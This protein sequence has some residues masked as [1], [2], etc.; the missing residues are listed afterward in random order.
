[1]KP[2][3]LEK[4]LAGEPVITRDGYKVFNIKCRKTDNPNNA[5]SAQIRMGGE[6]E[7]PTTF[8]I[9]KDGKMFPWMEHGFD[10]FMAEETDVFCHEEFDDETIKWRKAKAGR[11]F[12]K[13][14]VVLY[15]GD[16]DARLVRCAIY[17]CI[18]IHVEDL[19]KLP[20]E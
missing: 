11:N 15:N 2:F 10:L 16:P 19:L 12:G 13:D 7:H 17:D 5:L 18:Y 14:T 6:G 9:G 4:A 8:M 20:K 3:D 1:M